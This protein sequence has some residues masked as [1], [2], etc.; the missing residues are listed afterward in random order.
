MKNSLWKPNYSYLLSAILLVVFNITPALGA[1]TIE[2]HSESGTLQDIFKRV[3]QSSKEDIQRYKQLKEQKY[4]QL[5]EVN[6]Q[7]ESLK[8]KLHELNSSNAKL[9]EAILTLQQK[10]R[11]KQKQ[12]QFAQADIEE[13]IELTSAQQNNFISN[14]KPLA[15]WIDNQALLPVQKNNFS[16][17]SINKLWLAMVQQISASSRVNV[18]TGEILLPNGN[19]EKAPVQ[20]T[21]AFSQF[22]QDYGWLKFDGAR[23]QWRQISPQPQLDV[24]Q[25][26]WAIDPS[27]G[28]G[29]D[30]LANQ[31]KW[32]ETYLAAGIVGALIVVIAVIGFSIGI[33]RL[34]VLTKEKQAVKKQASQLSD[35][36]ENNM[37]GRVLFQLKNCDA[38]QQ[39]EDVVD[40]NVSREMPWL[41]RG[42]GTLAVLAAIA[43]LMGLLGTVG[44]MIETFSVITSQGVSDGEL[45]SGGIAEAL[46]TTKLGLLVAVPLL[47]L[48]CLVKTQAQQLAEIIEHQVTSLVVEIRYGNQETC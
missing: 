10:L 45:L 7:V 38:Q 8:I 12:V 41:F 42:I 20:L 19:I 44:G 4:D 32:Y 5:S 27:F 24:T 16:M 36:S 43:P 40:A 17:A 23:Q 28:F 6:G 9:E 15:T 34:L 39:M 26:Q 33:A 30:A 31:P 25:K 2:E 3:E 11:E 22:S 47:I 18:V 13:V 14:N 1:N 37:L 35:L 48:H 29:F 46:L 21:G